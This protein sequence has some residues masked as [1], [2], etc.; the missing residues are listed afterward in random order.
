[1]QVLTKYLV[2][3][4]LQALTWRDNQLLPLR[5]SSNLLH[6]FTNSSTSESFGRGHPNNLYS[7]SHALV[8]MDPRW[9]QRLYITICWKL[10]GLLH[11]CIKASWVVRSSLTSKDAKMVSIMTSSVDTYM[12]ASF[13]VLKNSLAT[14]SMRCFCKNKLH[15]ISKMFL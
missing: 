9:S 4:Q 6:H 14:I 7:S 11:P 1:M 5:S 15:N 13:E 10:F 12:V 2:V 3:T 8:V